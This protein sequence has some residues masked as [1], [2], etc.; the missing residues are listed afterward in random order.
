[1]KEQEAVDVT[2]VPD[3]PK[4]TPS[5]PFLEL[6]QE[7][8]TLIGLRAHEL[9]E[10]RGYVHG[11][12]RED[13]ARAQ[14]ETLVN[15]PI[16]IAETETELIIRADV[17]GFGEGDLE[18]RVV[19]SAVCITGSRKFAETPESEQTVYAERRA[20]RI[21]RAVSLPC[22]IDQDTADAALENG[23]LE[24]RLAKAASGKKVIVR[25]RAASA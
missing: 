25:A 9:F 5:D 2:A 22:E 11:F 10:A 12:D 13:W 23:T 20:D 19:P 24:I 4:L 1:M 17:P 16:R 18:I 21:F 14:S 3:T 7:V 8:Q 15:V 6:A